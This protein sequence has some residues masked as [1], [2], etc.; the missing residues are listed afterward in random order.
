MQEIQ[1]LG[2][3]AAIRARPKMYVGELN[4]CTPNLLLLE[5]LC[6]AREQAEKGLINTVTVDIYNG[7]VIIKDDGPG[8]DLT[9]LPTGITVA[10]AHLTQLFACKN[11]KA[12]ENREFC[13]MGMVVPVALSFTSS[14]SMFDKNKQMWYLSFDQ[15]KP[16]GHLSPSTIDS[17]I[18]DEDQKKGAF[19]HLVLDYKILPH[20]AF[21]PAVISEL[22]DLKCKVIVN[23]K[24]V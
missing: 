15:G 6:V 7:T 21:D 12:F 9:M 2:S 24:R 3:Y 11:A 5:L 19:I 14:F 10:E 16:N 1:V 23:D 18:F 22:A 17:N 13:K 8:W 20:T 4:E